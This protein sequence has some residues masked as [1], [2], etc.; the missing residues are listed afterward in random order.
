MI[1]GA[2]EVSNAERKI[3]RMAKAKPKVEKLSDDSLQLWRGAEQRYANAQAQARAAEIHLQG[4]KAFIVERYKLKTTD[5]VNA[6]TG[7]ITRGE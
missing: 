4:V 6:E 5:L 3:K 1:P 2:C 7:V